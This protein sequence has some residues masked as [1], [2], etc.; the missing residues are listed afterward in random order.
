AVAST[1]INTTMLAVFATFLFLFFTLL[2]ER[3]FRAEATLTIITLGSALCF[4]Y[5]FVSIFSWETLTDFFWQY[6]VLEKNKPYQDYFSLIGVIP[7]I[8][9]T[10]AVYFIVAKSEK[11]AY[12]FILPIFVFLIFEAISYWLFYGF[13]IRYRRVMY[14]LVLLT[15]LLSGYGAYCL[16]EKL[17]NMNNFLKTHLSKQIF[18][19][20]AISFLVVIATWTHLGTQDEIQVLVNPHEDK[21]FTILGKI[22]PDSMVF[23]HHLESFSLPYYNLKP[24]QLS[25]R[26]AGNKFRY[27]S[28]LYRIYPHGELAKFSS[29][30]DWLDSIHKKGLFEWLDKRPKSDYYLYLPLQ[31]STKDFD[32]IIDSGQS[33]VLR[34]NH[35][36]A[37]IE[38]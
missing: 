23:A 5:I 19:F 15:P 28:G 21:V 25:P 29:F 2:W 13:F 27:E 1:H 30:F 33:S 18:T 9:N 32:K 20:L 35:R 12:S 4:L 22:S 3:R 38:S 11:R 8:L 37:H 10:L 26:H 6:L 7:A 34:W 17:S 31:K 24:L 16:I 36:V 14:F